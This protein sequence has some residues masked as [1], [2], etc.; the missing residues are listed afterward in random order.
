VNEI[1]GNS[2]KHSQFYK[3]TICKLQ[4]QG[5]FGPTAKVLIVNGGDFDAAVF[6]D[7]GFKDVTIANLDERVTGESPFA[8]YEWSFQ[9]TENLDYPDDSFDYVVVHSGL[10]HLRC[11]PKGILEMYRVARKGILGF[12]P[13]DCLFTRLG[14]KLG[15]GQAYET[16]AVYHNKLKWGGVANTAVPNYVYR[17]SA[18]DLV[19]TIQVNRPIG[20]HTFRFFYATRTPGRLMTLKN[21]LLRF[22]GGIL[23]SVFDFL[24]HSSP[25]LANNI[26][27]YVGKAPEE[28]F[29]WLKEDDGEILPDRE[30]LDRIYQS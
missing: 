25:L 29:P 4:A 15:F 9:N 21:P 3:G 2:E 17:F 19:R 8:P 7:L 18:R 16:A 5:T 12:E 14:V 30:Y 10:H 1:A 24:E 11:P 23:S 27:F 28:L 20:K 13:H 26:A 6:Q 22:G